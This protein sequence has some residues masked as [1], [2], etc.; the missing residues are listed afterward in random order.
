LYTVSHIKNIVFTYLVNSLNSKDNNIVFYNKNF[1]IKAISQYFSKF[2]NY[3]DKDIDRTAITF[4]YAIIQL[5]QTAYGY[6]I[7]IYTNLFFL[8]Y[9]TNFM[10][11][12]ELIP[13]TY[14]A[15]HNIR[16]S[17]CKFLQ[18]LKTVIISHFKH[19][20]KL[21]SRLT[22]LYCNIKKTNKAAV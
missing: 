21:F 5:N 6:Y 17:M 20:N 3:S 10:T 12:D 1:I 22:V 19:L 18:D 11:E 16:I 8:K 13:L 14:K 4:K 15:A 2:T 7:Y 9:L